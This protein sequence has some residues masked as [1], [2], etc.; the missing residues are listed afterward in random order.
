MVAAVQLHTSPTL[1]DDDLLPQVVSWIV[2][3]GIGAA[4]LVIVYLAPSP[5]VPIPVTTPAAPSLIFE[6]GLGPAQPR[7]SAIRGGASAEGA[8][9]PRTST[10][11]SVINAAGLFTAAA[12]AGI[13]E[14][15]EQFIPGV[16]GVNGDVGTRAAAAKS[17]LSANG[18]DTRPG[19]ARMN[20]GHRAAA[21]SASFG[22]VQGSSSIAHVDV[23]VR[24]LPVVQAAPLGAETADATEMGSFVRGR[25]AQLQTCYERAGGSDLAGVVA[26]RVTI[27]AGGTVQSAEIARR[28]WSGPGASATEGCLL[29]IVKAWRIP[30]AAEGTTVTIPISFTR[31]G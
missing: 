2:A 1:R 23:H 7:P 26:L 6:S 13:V 21:G 17:A 27:G 5:M 20:G 3:A 29:N 14:H 4:W 15:I 25:V 31:G 8:V 19:M 11:R 16:I 28:S 24:P 12:T 18:A 9:H 22:R 10:S 30:F